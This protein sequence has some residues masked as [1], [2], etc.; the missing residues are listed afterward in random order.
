MQA[1]ELVFTTAVTMSQGKA[2]VDQIWTK[3][4]QIWANVRQKSAHLATCGPKNPG[5]PLQVLACTSP[6][7]SAARPA[8]ASA[9]RAAARPARRGTAPPPPYRGAGALGRTLRYLID[10][11]AHAH[12]CR[13]P[14][15]MGRTAEANRQRNRGLGLHM[16]AVAAGNGATWSAADVPNSRRTPPRS[17]PIPR[18]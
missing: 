16:R 3:V 18:K 6:R 9:P 7:S 2:E 8:A 14:A 13:A 5:V 11:P 12:V 10:V 4:C 17:D 1:L 15:C